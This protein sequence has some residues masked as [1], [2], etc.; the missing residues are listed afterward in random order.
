MIHSPIVFVLNQLQLAKLSQQS[1]QIVSGG[2]L[3]DIKLVQKSFD[4]LLEGH[5]ALKPFPDKG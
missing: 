4:Q 5:R 2:F 3:R 1:S